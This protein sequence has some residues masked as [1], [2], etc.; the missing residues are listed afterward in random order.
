MSVQLKESGETISLRQLFNETL[1]M[2]DT[3][4]LKDK[5]STVFH[6]YA[7]NMDLDEYS[8]SKDIADHSCKFFKASDVP[9]IAEEDIPAE[10]SNLRFVVDCNKVPEQSID[11]IF[12]LENN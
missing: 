3:T 12:S 1:K 5:L 11:D 6:E 10:I 4:E 2:L 9:S 7:G 8:F